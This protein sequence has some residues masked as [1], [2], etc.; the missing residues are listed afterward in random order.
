MVGETIQLLFAA[1]FLLFLVYLLGS[2][3]LKP[4]RLVFKILINSFFGLLILWAFNFFG[5]YF[6]FF[7]PLNWL[8]V[9]IVGFLGLPGLVLLIF[10]RLV[11]GS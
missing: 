10:L 8:T 11:L 3:F 7:I 6:H 1:L 4:L 9:L 5:A 2:I